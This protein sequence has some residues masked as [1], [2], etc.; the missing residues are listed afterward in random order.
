MKKQ[1]RER[2]DTFLK[3]NRG[4][5]SQVIHELWE[6]RNEAV[7]AEDPYFFLRL[8]ER[9]ETSG[10]S[11]FAHDIL[12]E[13]VRVFPGHLQVTQRYCLSLIKCGFLVTARELLTRL[14]KDGH[15]DE[16]TLG[17]L[18]RVYKEMWLS[19]GSG[20]RGHPHLAKSQELYLGAFRRSR[21]YYSGIN[22][23]SLSLIMGKKDLSRKVARKVLRICADLL[24]DPSQRSYWL[25][26]TVA[27]AFLV[28]GRQE[29]AAKFYRLARA[30][31]SRNYSN[32]ASTRRQL[33]LLARYSTVHPAVL[34]TLRIPPVIAFTGHMIDAPGKPPGHFPQSS[35]AAVKQSIAAVLRKLD[36][37]IGFASAACGS[38]ILFHE[39][40][41]A[42]GGESNVVLPFDK[43]D[44]FATSV[45]PAGPAW[46]RRARAVL[47]KSS[48]VE[49]ATSGG[50]TSGNELLFSYANELIMGKAIL[51][52]RFL[53][54]EPLL[55]AVWDGQRNGKPGGTSDCIREWEQTGFPYIVIDPVTATVEDR[56]ASSRQGRA[57]KPRTA[58]S[59]FIHAAG[60]EP[61]K[62]RRTVA[63]L[64]ADMVGYSKL[65]E[66]Q[67]PA[68]VRGF[69]SGVSKTLRESTAEPLYKNTWGDAICLA[70]D[71]PLK[72]AE[73]AIALRDM[74]R[75]TDWSRLDLPGTL[76][77]RI[78]LHAGP[79]Y[80]VREPLL[81]RL[82]VFGF[83]VNQA[84]RIEPIT[85]PGN[86]YA[87]ES[88]AALLF[89]DPTNRLDC[90]YVGDIVLPKGFGKY[91]IYHI[92]R[93][94][95][96][97]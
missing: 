7:W 87:S 91:R 94:T 80:C 33:T 72:A 44:F 2:F 22:A 4:R 47:A 93:L 42:R 53:E 11:L 81:E 18:G 67:V 50:Y 48:L 46:A 19:E 6:S 64:F 29:K 69:L 84:A 88:F 68:Y 74:V 37:R 83:H 95:E 59:H 76:S 77:V 60:R 96:A 36:A 75:G 70:F 20:E 23:A 24:K 55:I 3:E 58:R 34:D 1:N 17:I 52:S 63:I 97:G 26:A 71:D 21:G 35:A 57:A 27:E 39:C 8:G 51:R 61:G 56:G 9:A 38:D 28:L 31:S 15:F 89:T 54:T 85:S 25:L 30:R 82:N 86:V 78:G 62:E 73:C 5:L 90:R 66:E 49:Q 32:L 40:L 10:Q 12:K 43:E 65:H 13:G 45:N 92:K 14:M 16:E 79:V 41:L